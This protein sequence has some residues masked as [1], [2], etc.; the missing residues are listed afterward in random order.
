MIN[1]YKDYSWLRGFNI[2]PSWGASIQE[3]WLRYS[4]AAFRKELEML[5][6][7]HANC[8]RLWLDPSVW[9][10]SPESVRDCFLDAIN[11]IDEFGMRTMPVLSNR[12]HD[13]RYDYGGIYMENFVDMRPEAFQVYTSYLK[14]IATPFKSDER[15]LIWDLCNEPQMSSQAAPAAE[16]ILLGRFADTL[17]RIDV[18]QP[19]TIGTHYSG[20][21]INIYA[22]LCN[23]LSCHPYGKTIPEL[24]QQLEQA[25][26][27]SEGWGKPIMANETIPGAED[28]L[29]RAD[30]LKKAIP[31]FEQ[32]GT[33]WMGWSF[34]YGKAV[35]TRRDRVDP[36][37]ICGCGFHAWTNSNGTLRDGL[38]FLKDKPSRQAP[39]KNS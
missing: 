5:Q 38:D 18:Q 20:Q 31:L 2:I 7:L 25:K 22:H 26:S 21:N 29:I 34:H 35:S 13:V 3:A 12:W 15:I 19:I 37:G 4:P 32:Y 27:I 14:D 8:I 36:N 28:D 1:F 24:T 16:L 9:M 39:W 11:A 33:G 6:T 10:L 30:Y 17:R 23:V